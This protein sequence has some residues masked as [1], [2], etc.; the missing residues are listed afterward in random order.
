MSIENTCQ[1]IACYLEADH[2]DASM[3]AE[4]IVFTIMATSDEHKGLHSILK[5]LNTISK[6][7]ALSNT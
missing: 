7:A 5:L 2:D 1:G 3:L 6:S 4:D